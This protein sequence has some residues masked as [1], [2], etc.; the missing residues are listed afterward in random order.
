MWYLLGGILWVIFAFWPAIVARR[1]G[2]SFLLFFL[3]SLVFFVIALVVAYLIKDKT[4]TAKDDADDAAVER[5]LE[6]EDAK[7]HKA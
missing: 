6:H 1:K 4:R 2:Y 3:F 7:A 5:A